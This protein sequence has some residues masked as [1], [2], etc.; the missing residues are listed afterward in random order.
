M[1]P[2]LVSGGVSER[3]MVTVLKTVVQRCT[4]GS[5]PSSSACK[6]LVSD[7]D[8]S[9]FLMSKGDIPKDLEKSTSLA[10]SECS[11]PSKVSTDVSNNTPDEQENNKENNKK[12]FID[13]E[14]SRVIEVWPGLPDAIRAGIIAMVGSSLNEKEG[15]R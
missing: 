2:M 13:P 6:E 12:T 5:N 7:D 3:L 8:T 14:L 10:D 15:G 9:S 4:G 11:D 1:L